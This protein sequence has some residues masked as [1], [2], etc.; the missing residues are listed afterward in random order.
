MTLPLTQRPPPLASI[1]EGE[2]HV[3]IGLIDVEEELVKD[4]AADARRA[5][6]LGWFGVRVRVRVWVSVRG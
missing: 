4:S 5:S 6:H 3:F 2:L 1:G